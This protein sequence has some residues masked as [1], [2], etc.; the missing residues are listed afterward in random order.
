MCALP[1]SGTVHSMSFAYWT[2][3]GRSLARNVRTPGFAR[4][5]ATAGLRRDAGPKAPT[6]FVLDAYPEADGVAVE[7]GEVAYRRSNLDPMEQY[8]LAVLAKLREPRRIFEIGTYDGASTV[9]LA[10]NAPNAQILT[11]DLPPAHARAATVEKEVENAAAGAGSRFRSAPE[12]ERIT[13]LYG[14]SRMFDFSPWL[15]SVDLVLV[16]AGHDYDCAHADTVN[17]LRLL[18][19]GGL[20]VWDDYQVGWPGVVRAVDECRQPVR[21]IASTDLAVFDSARR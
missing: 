13:Q 3:A 7:M 21:H 14:D 5:L 20:I 16:D 15:G 18:A 19:P 1:A 12:A 17:A 11:L 6:V 2:E 10:R 8:V 9:L 4:E